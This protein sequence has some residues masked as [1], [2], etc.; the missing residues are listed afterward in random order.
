MDFARAVN[1][2]LVIQFTY[3]GL[4]RIVQPAAFGLTTRGKQALRG[5]QIGGRSKRNPI[6]CWDLYLTDKMVG[7]ELT[8]ESFTAFELVG[9]RKGDLGFSVIFAE[10]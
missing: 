1:H 9:Y 4:A 10:H 3:D 2:R 8:G 5:C 7:P 6:P